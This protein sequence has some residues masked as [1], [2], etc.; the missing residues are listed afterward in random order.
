MNQKRN[1]SPT[2]ESDESPL[3]SWPTPPE[4]L[5]IPPIKQSFAQ[6]S[7]ISRNVNNGYFRATGMPVGGGRFN[8]IER[9]SFLTP[10]NPISDSSRRSAFKVSVK[11]AYSPVFLSFTKSFFRFSSRKKIRTTQN[12]PSESAFLRRTSRKTDQL[13]TTQSMEFAWELGILKN[14]LIADSFF[15]HSL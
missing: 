9:K 12:S 15:F 10:T 4:A 11:N 13:T 5:E 3:E 8:S 6:I 7:R 1:R 14:K 2:F